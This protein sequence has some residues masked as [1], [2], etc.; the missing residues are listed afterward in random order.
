VSSNW[1]GHAILEQNFIRQSSSLSRH[2]EGAAAAAKLFVEENVGKSLAE[3][4]F[5]H[6]RLSLLSR[7]LM[8]DAL[9]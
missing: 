7:L 5:M 4:C 6:E 3:S 8:R 1:E 2:E 9:H